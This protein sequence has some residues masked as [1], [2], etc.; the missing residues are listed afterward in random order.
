MVGYYRSH[1]KFQT[2]IVIH[3]SHSITEPEKY[4]Q[5]GNGNGNG[6]ATIEMLSN[7]LFYYYR[8]NFASFFNF[9]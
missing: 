2:I 5:H 8:N 9:F 6:T 7:L 1:F 4:N 3:Y